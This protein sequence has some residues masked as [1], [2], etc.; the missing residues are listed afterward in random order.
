MRTRYLL[1][2][3][4]D[5]KEPMP[6]ES[7]GPWRVAGV[8]LHIAPTEYTLAR[9]NKRMTPAFLVVDEPEIEL[10]QPPATHAV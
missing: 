7:K 6:S 10:H 9:T 4:V 2:N 1:G 5:L 3:Q 8:K